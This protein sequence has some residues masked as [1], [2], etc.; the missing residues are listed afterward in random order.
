MTFQYPAQCSNLVQ[1]LR[2]LPVTLLIMTLI[3]SRDL[4]AK[5]DGKRPL[6]R[7]RYR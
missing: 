4:V 1:V 6:G 5:P 7:Y 3:L 2:V